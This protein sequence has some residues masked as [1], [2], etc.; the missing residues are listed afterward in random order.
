MLYIY[1]YIIVYIYI[2]HIQYFDWW[3]ISAIT[4]W[5][6]ELKPKDHK[7][8]D[9]Q[10]MEGVIAN[11]RLQCGHM[12]WRSLL[13]SVNLSLEAISVLNDHVPHMLIIF[14]P[15]NQILRKN[16][17]NLHVALAV[18]KPKAIGLDCMAKGT[19]QDFVHVKTYMMLICAYII[20]IVPFDTHYPIFWVTFQQLIQ[21]EPYLQLLYIMYI[22]SYIST[23]RSDKEQL[24][25]SRIS[26][27]ARGTSSF[28]DLGHCGLSITQPPS[29]PSGW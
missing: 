15:R 18:R 12:R 4:L 26:A 13:G 11:S 6:P 17:C 2:W 16:L 25:S 10:S 3:K 28:V 7:Q 22:S 24:D 29:E 21:H 8:G 1:I 27:K 5:T 14:R 9:K 23:D 20:W 19:L